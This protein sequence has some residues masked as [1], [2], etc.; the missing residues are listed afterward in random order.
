MRRT[1]LGAGLLALGFG[2]ASCGAGGGTPEFTA[3]VVDAANA[4][5]DAVEQ[6]LNATLE[7]FRVSV[8]PQVAVLVIDS[9]GNQ[10]IEDYGI[11]I[12]RKWGIGDKQRDDG[13]L[14]LIALDDRTL[15]IETGS[16][17]EGDLTDV[18]AGRIIDGVVVPELRNDDPTA[19]VAAGV[20][21]LITELSGET[22]AYPDEAPNS[23]TATTTTQEVGLAGAVFGFFVI[24]VFGLGVIG[25]MVRGRRRGLGALDVLSILYIF[26]SGS[27]GGF[28]GGRG[29]GGFGGGGGGGFSGGGASGSW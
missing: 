28:G 21:A 6:D 29:M 19:A 10:S 26:T 13:A 27:R 25:M 9:T 14:L 5:D 1:A 2:L 16:G 17:I 22:F 18:E 12:A 8:G 23:T 7:Q 24:L 3:P 15:R 4:I 11:D 20:Q